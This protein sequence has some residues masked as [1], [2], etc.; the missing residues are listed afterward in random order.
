MNRISRQLLGSEG[1]TSDSAFC[2]SESSLC[3]EPLTTQKNHNVT[4]NLSDIPEELRSLR[5]KLGLT[6]TE[7]GGKLGISQ[8]YVAQ[9]ETEAV[10]ASPRVAQKILEMSGHSP[11]KIESAMKK[12]PEREINFGDWV[13]EQ[14]VRQG[15]TQ[16]ELAKK[17]GI[18]NL[19]V[20]FIENH[21]TESPRQGT[22]DAMKNVLGEL[23]KGVRTEVVES[24]DWGFGE[25]QGPF[26]FKE[27]EKNIDGD[28]SG[29]YIFYDISKHPV[30]IGESKNIRKRILDHD[31]EF[32]FKPPIVSTIGYMVVKDEGVRAKLEAAMIKI[33]GETAILNKQNKI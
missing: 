33:A 10:N 9:I 24:A 5:K 14:R 27:W 3:H 26:P 6:Q 19:T 22:M 28:T 16:Q 25:F 18:S 32:W 1:G 13:R 4:S 30:Y 21:Q 2:L 15:L 17:A 31:R 12:T 8:G 7:M 20:S 23:P 29:I 11:A